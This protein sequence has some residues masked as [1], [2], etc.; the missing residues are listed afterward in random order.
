[1]PKTNLINTQQSPGPSFTYSGFYDQ[2]NT[3][4][5]QL[6]FEA[7][8]TATSDGF[9]WNPTAVG[10]DIIDPDAITPGD[11]VVIEFD[12]NTSVVSSAEY[13]I[14][15]D[16][17]NLEYIG[18]LDMRVGIEGGWFESPAQS[19]YSTNELSEY[20]LTDDNGSFAARITGLEPG[21]STKLKFKVRRNSKFT[22]SNLIF[23]DIENDASIATGQDV[24]ADQPGCIM[25]V[26]Q[27]T[28]NISPMYFG[29]ESPLGSEYGGLYG[30]TSNQQ[31]LYAGSNTPDITYIVSSPAGQPTTL[32][33]Y[34]EAGTAADYR[35]AFWMF[36]SFSDTGNI[37]EDMYYAP[38]ARIFDVDEGS[39]A[40]S[41][42]VA[43]FAIAG[44][45]TLANRPG[46]K[47]ALL[48]PYDGG[49]TNTVRTLRM[50]FRETN[51]SYGPAL[52]EYIVKVHP[53]GTPPP[54]N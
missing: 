34:D 22:V 52:L 51:I 1:V 49:S 26:A 43:K 23:W 32:D 53:V 13:G 3:P 33:I 5:A 30:I 45:W 19:P 42:T 48:W 10:D 36:D 9:T 12:I 38:N 35:L 27:E 21:S 17:Q 6:N 40:S 29:T 20:V 37:A 25:N 14:K 50:E 8:F 47:L 11:K 28:A 31:N 44:S 2:F 46:V 54:N 16:I 39:Q 18:G 24:S 7:A 15:F 4:Q 41:A